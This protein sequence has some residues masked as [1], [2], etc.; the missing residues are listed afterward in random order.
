MGA[1]RGPAG[2][3]LNLAGV[4]LSSTGAA[5]LGHPGTNLRDSGVSELGFGRERTQGENPRRWFPAA[6]GCIVHAAGELPT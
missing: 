1:G 5:P 3:K 2:P 4:C 6:R